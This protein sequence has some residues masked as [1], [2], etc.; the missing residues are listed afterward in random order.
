[1]QIGSALFDPISHDDSQEKNACFRFAYL[2]GFARSF[3][4]GGRPDEYF[5]VGSI[6]RAS[7]RFLQAYTGTSSMIVRVQEEGLPGIWAVIR[8]A[9][10]SSSIV[11]VIRDVIPVILQ[12][13]RMSTAS[14]MIVIL[15]AAPAPR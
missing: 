4:A 7:G 5:I 8:M 6:S 14:R 2:K 3:P 9:V 13:I 1:M 11:F 10:T 12:V 15:M